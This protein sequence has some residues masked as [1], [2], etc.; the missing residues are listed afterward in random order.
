MGPVS[1]QRTA[2][3]T[4]LGGPGFPS[5]HQPESAPS[6]VH[7]SIEVAANGHLIRITDAPHKGQLAAA[8][9]VGPNDNLID[10][11]ATALVALKLQPRASS[12]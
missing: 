4:L 7:I 2:I 9:V 1:G 3:P 11:L 6:M 5:L 10:V 8:Y 12:E